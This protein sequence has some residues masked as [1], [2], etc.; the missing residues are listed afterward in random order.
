[1]RFWPKIENL[2]AALLFFKMFISNADIKKYMNETYNHHMKLF[3]FWVYVNLN[4]GVLIIKK[5][6][7]KVQK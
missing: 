4:G 1:M 2:E 3:I 6:V 7:R 5:E